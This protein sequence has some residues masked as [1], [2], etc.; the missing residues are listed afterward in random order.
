MPPR[1]ARV[2][3][4]VR[5]SFCIFALR[6]G[7]CMCPALYRLSV[8]N[9]KVLFMKVNKQ[10]LTKQLKVKKGLS[11]IIDSQDDVLRQ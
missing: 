7:A 3:N 8:V 6:V 9:L 5:P 2:V 10:I 11:M 4:E 1:I